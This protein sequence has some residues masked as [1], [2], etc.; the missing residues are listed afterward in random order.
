MIQLSKLG[1][2]YV[3]I[4]T[5][6]YDDEIIGIYSELE[7]ALEATSKLRFSEI[8]QYKLDSSQAWEDLR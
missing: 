2:V 4:D 5:S 6:Y 7:L 3:V 1:V 8:R